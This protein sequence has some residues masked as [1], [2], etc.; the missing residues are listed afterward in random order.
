MLKSMIVGL[1]LLASP[2]VAQTQCLETEEAYEM[3][4]T[5]KFQPVFSGTFAQGIMEIWGGTGDDGNLAWIAFVTMPDG[6]SCLLT[7][8][9]AFYM[10]EL[11]PNV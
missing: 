1:V 9:T 5:Q 7:E 4:S 10:Q 2:A 6:K 11:L 8:G 3:L